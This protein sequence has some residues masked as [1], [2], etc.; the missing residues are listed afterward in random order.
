M[1]E[2]VEST[3]EI[4]VR[5]ITVRDIKMDEVGNDKAWIIAECG[6]YVNATDNR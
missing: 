2:W 4:E 3:Q 5:Q 6:S 1:K